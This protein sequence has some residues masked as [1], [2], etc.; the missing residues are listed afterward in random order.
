MIFMSIAVIEA[1]PATWYTVIPK[2]CIDNQI[3]MA[4]IDP[5]I[6]YPDAVAGFC[7]RSVN[8]LNNTEDKFCKFFLYYIFAKE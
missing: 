7:Q 1:I 3:L 5:V 4:Q 8:F 2:E 6:D